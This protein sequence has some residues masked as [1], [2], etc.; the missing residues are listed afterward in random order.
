[1]QRHVAA[2]AQG[3]NTNKQ[4]Q[5][6]RTLIL[7]NEHEIVDLLWNADPNGVLKMAARAAM[8]S[9][10]LMDKVDPDSVTW[11]CVNGSRTLCFE[12]KKGK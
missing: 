6:M 10:A 5:N 9:P 12:V 4:T 11:N 7:I 3:K 8:M 2:P 1:M